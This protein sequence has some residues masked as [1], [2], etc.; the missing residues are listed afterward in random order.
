MG[1][2]VLV[3]RALRFF[4][5]VCSIKTLDMQGCEGLSIRMILDILTRCP[6]LEV[7]K[8]RSVSVSHLRSNL[9]P[10]NCL[11]LKRLGVFFATDLTRPNDDPEFV[12]EQLSRLERLETLD[13]NSRHT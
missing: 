6:L 2:R 5:S 10:W 13:L 9:E 4:D 12:F 1:H 11:R 7:F 3:R 8:A